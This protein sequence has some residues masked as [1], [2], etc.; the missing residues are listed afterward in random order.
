MGGDASDFPDFQLDDEDVVHA[1]DNLI[2]FLS[3]D[4]SA[5]DSSYVKQVQSAFPDENDQKSFALRLII[6][7]HGDIHQPLHTVAA[8]DQLYPEGDIGGNAEQIPEKGDSG[9]TNLHSVWDSVL[10]EHCGYAT[11]PTTSEAWD[12]LTSDAEDIYTTY[13]IDQ[14]QLNAAEY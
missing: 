12:T 5:D 13:P 9:V 11:L 7:Y 2:K 14:S 3:D 8:V 4:P 10:Y 6:H 1:L